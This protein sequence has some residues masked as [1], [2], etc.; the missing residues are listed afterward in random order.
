[1][2]EEEVEEEEEERSIRPQPRLPAVSKW[3]CPRVSGR[4]IILRR[5]RAPPLARALL[6]GAPPRRSSSVT[7]MEAQTRFAYISI[8]HGAEQLGSRS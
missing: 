7:P 6:L 8:N 3:A 5:S 1:V 4:R 2:E